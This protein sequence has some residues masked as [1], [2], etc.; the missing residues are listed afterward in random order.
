MPLERELNEAQNTLVKMQQDIQELNTRRSN[1]Q[2]EIEKKEKDAQEKIDAE[3][4]E[5]KQRMEEERLAL[6][7]EKE[8]FATFVNTEKAKLASQDDELKKGK[9]QLNQD[10]QAAL[11]EYSDFKDKL[12]SGLKDIENQKN[13]WIARSEALEKIAKEQEETK[14]GQDER[15][16]YLNNLK[17][18]TEDAIE[19]N[20]KLLADITFQQTAVDEKYQAIKKEN[21]YTREA[22]QYFSDL[23]KQLKQKEED[24]CKLE[25]FKDELVRLEALKAEVELKI[26]QNTALIEE[27]AN[28][29]IELDEREKDIKKQQDTLTLV[30]CKNDRIFQATKKLREELIASST[31]K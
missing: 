20:K 1:L 15:E 3:Y 10:R 27:Y 30:I 2:N 24:I 31:N 28:K 26:K 8:D 16:F 19:K 14:K 5:H 21:D 23:L 6:S 9:E 18:Q 12:E 29:K 7:K 11:K 22:I 25:S 17:F 13:A 4:S